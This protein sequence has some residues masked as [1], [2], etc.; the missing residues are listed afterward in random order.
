M[1]D[2]P[3][4]ATLLS[5]GDELVSGLTVDT[6][7]ASAA[8]QLRA[9]GVTITG[10]RTVGDEQSHIESAVREL[11][12]GHELL[13][14]TGGIGPTPD[15][16]TRQAVAAVAGQALVE[17]ETWTERIRDI[18]TR[19]GRPMPESNRQQ[20]TYPTGG[21]L[22]NNPIGTAGGVR[23][24]LGECEVFVLPGVPREFEAMMVE[25]VLPW[26]QSQVAER[27][28]GVHRERAIHT[29]GRGESDIAEQLADLLKRNDDPNLSVGTTASN[30][31]V[32][33]RA[34]AAGKTEANANARLDQVE[35]TV[36]HTLGELVFGTDDTTLPS[37]VMQLLKEQARLVTF[38]E[39]CTGGLCAKL[40][41]DLPGSSDVFHRS[42]VTY[43]NDAKAEMLGVPTE[44]LEKHGAVS[45]EVA[46]AMAEGALNN[47]PAASIAASLTGIAGPGGGSEL[48][49]VGT[50]CFGLAMEGR[51]T[52]THRLHLHGNRAMVRGRAAMTAL[53][54]IRLALQSN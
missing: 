47:D 32:S 14:I 53:N 17:D 42:V 20:S 36:R 27:G 54:F 40:L 15:D 37:A 13:L 9:A 30:A 12:T 18:W 4:L 25:H 10:H 29:F 28:G 48:K 26:T 38:A 8:R 19:R 16:L 1:P 24:S 34:Y 39:S 5:I 46:R 31:V 23:V 2:R 35:Q 22:L 7:S 11:A 45:E 51:P 3:V 43:A 49:P 21:S 41:T 6:N 33:I 44:L 50:V 52:Q